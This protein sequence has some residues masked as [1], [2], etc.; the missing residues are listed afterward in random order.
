MNYGVSLDTIEDAKQALKRAWPEIKNECRAVL[1][2]ELHYQAQI[3]HC[4]RTS[5]SV[6]ILQL[7][8]NVKMYIE[9]CQTELFQM[10]DEKKHEDFRGG[11]ET[12]PDIVIF[13]SNIKADWRRR[14]RDKT[15]IS[16][17]LAIEVKASE[18]H[19]GRLRPGEICG[20]ISKLSAHRE[21]VRAKASDFLP[22]MMIIDTT[23][24]LSERMLP[25]AIEVSKA[26][27]HDSEVE[28]MYVSRSVSF[29][30]L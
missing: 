16:T 17:L 4:L 10:L 24:E 2:S 27:A 8:M 7:G 19:R 13:T 23:D 1:G 18:R 30:S 28:F 25:S 20:D 3:Y 22:V 21:K 12:I 6:P 11:F 14:N 5:G 26:H 9:N 29:S 15:L